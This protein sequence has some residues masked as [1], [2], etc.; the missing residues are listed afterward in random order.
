[1]RNCWFTSDTHFGHQG[2]LEY[3]K[4]SRPFNSVEEM[5]EAIINR[6][7]N[8]VS[9]NDIVYHLGDVAF[10]K[11]NLAHVGRL[12]GTKILIMGNHDCYPVTEYLPYFKKVFGMVYFK[13]C[14]L[15]HM[16]VHS[17]GLGARWFLNLHGHLHS[18]NVQQRLYDIWQ[19]QID[20]KDVDLLKLDRTIHD[21]N[22][23]NVSVEQNNLTPIH[24]DLIVER[25]KELS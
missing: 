6:W 21:R 12:K 16:P 14:V 18:N 3:E 8:C 1:M 2:I 22:Y 15:S 10:G 4:E 9:Y 24:W 7:N 13:N 20:G 17:E 19:M 23:F 25:L 5:N 11:K